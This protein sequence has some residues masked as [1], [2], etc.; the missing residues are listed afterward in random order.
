MDADISAVASLIGDPTRARMLLALM[1]G[2]ARPAGELA[3]SANVAPQTA[4]AHLARLLEGRLLCAEPQGR[5][6]Y[7]RLASSDVAAIIEALAAIAPQRSRPLQPRR[8]EDH[9]LRF[10][11]S[12]YNHLAGVLAV[13]VT[14]ALGTRGLLH[15]GPDNAYGVTEQGS[16]WFDE[17]GINID[18]MSRGR[19]PVARAC[20]DWT[21]RRHHLG[22]PL[23]TAVLQR[24]L[25]M[26]WLARADKTRRLRVTTKG[27]EQF[28]KAL[29]IVCS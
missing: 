15:I 19:R 16:V 3:M 22:G 7:Y 28:Y 25:E 11:R 29:G 14:D 6:R 24:L 27:R 26:K 13:Q 5:H 18:D 23:G 21:E 9:P 2:V 12:C 4:S 8:V 1:G 20:L 17:F 10:A